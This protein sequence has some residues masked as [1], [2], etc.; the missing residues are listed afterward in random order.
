[1]LS[2]KFVQPKEY[3]GVKT[4]EKTTEIESLVNGC[5]VLEE[6][7]ILKVKSIITRRKQSLIWFQLT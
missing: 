5:Y 2:A 4:L 7:K 1:M 3:Y 6:N